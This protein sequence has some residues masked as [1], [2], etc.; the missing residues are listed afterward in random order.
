MVQPG[1][2]RSSRI[3]TLE[4]ESLVTL[5]AEFI[6]KNILEHVVHFHLEDSLRI[7]GFET[8]EI[9]REGG[10]IVANFRKSFHQREMLKDDMI[11]VARGLLREGGAVRLSWVAPFQVWNGDTLNITYKLSW[12]YGRGGDDVYLP[13]R[14]PPGVKLEFSH[15]V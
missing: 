1:W 10:V 13:D 4:V 12:G 11:V 6:D 14:S 5:T 8:G 9:T 7:E 2:S 3:L 15:A